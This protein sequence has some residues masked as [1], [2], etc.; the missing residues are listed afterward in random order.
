MD[1]H[2]E[3]TRNNQDPSLRTQISEEWFMDSWLT[4]QNRVPPDSPSGPLPEGPSRSSGI[5]TQNSTKWRINHGLSLS[6]DKKQ[7]STKWRINYGLQLSTARNNHGS[8]LRTQL[9]EKSIM[10]YNSAPTRNNK[11][12]SLISDAS[13][14]LIRDQQLAKIQVEKKSA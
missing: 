12:L 13:G 8:S 4:P 6:T 10:D 2:P 1:Y 5:I 3:S 9:C 11:G 14:E 7:D